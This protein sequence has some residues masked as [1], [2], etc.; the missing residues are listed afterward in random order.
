MTALPRY[1]PPSQSPVGDGARGRLQGSR[2]RLDSAQLCNEVVSHTPLSQIVTSI[3]STI[4]HSLCVERDLRL[5]HSV[6]MESQDKN[7]GPNNLRAWRAFR[8]LTQAQLAERVGT[9][10]NMIGYLEAGERALSAKWLRKLADA[11]DTTAGMLLDH[12]PHNIDADILEIWGKA[13][14]RE[15]RQISEIA[16]TLLRD[17]T[18]G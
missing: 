11:L 2:Y 18:N 12:D 4:S 10:S 17:G 16:R 14:P 7:G 13:G 5:L 9:N 3:A 6:T 8:G 1:F 15:R